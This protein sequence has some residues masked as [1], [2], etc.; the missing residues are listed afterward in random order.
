MII[1]VETDE[2][3]HC[4]FKKIDRIEIIGKEYSPRGGCWVFDWLKPLTHSYDIY[5]IIT[6][7]F[8]NIVQGLIALK[9]NYDEAYRCVDVEI[10]ESAPHNKKELNKKI[11]ND[12]NYVGVGK[13]LVAFACQYSI[14]KGLE[15]FIA[16]TSKT[17]K[18]PFYRDLGAIS[19]YGQQM[20]FD[21]D[22]SVHLA[23]QYFTGGVKWWK[24]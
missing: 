9:P 2:L 13:C 20:M 18:I 15:G 1:N 5:G 16:L 21:A 12:R 11:N 23:K 14:D 4:Y 6:E 17:P 24:K 10:I 7:E 22:V 8:P 3:V 19:I